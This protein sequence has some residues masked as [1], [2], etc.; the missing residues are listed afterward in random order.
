MRVAV[1]HSF[2]SSTLPSGENQVVQ[3]QVDALRQAGHSVTLVSRHTDMEAQSPQYAV[4]TAVRVAS[5]RGP[6]PTQY[7]ARFRPDV[8]HVHNLFPNIGT[9]WLEKWSGPVVATLHNFRPLC[10]NGLLLRDGQSCTLCPSGARWSSLKYACYR[11]SRPATLPLTLRNRKGPA[12]DR[13][14]RRADVLV[15]LSERSRLTYQEFGLPPAKLALVPNFVSRAHLS[16]RPMPEEVRWIAAGRLTR[17]KGF[18]NLLKMWPNGLPLEIFG[19]GPDLAELQHL[20]GGK[21]IA[22]MGPIDRGE[23]RRRLSEYT[24]LVLPSE[25]RENLP[26][27][28]LESFEAGLPVVARAGSGGADAVEDSGAG[29]VY[30]DAPSLGVALERVRA[31]GDQLRGLTRRAF[32]DTWAADTWLKAMEDQY[33]LAIGRR[34]AVAR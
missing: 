16:H 34:A 27:V 7:I 2:Y 8:V 21:A 24:G 12:H 22:I 31:G 28:V 1:V 18:L 33:R 29:T 20:A 6:D 9:R 30:F 26:S 15:V 11:N 13:L 19:D 5:G 10:A 4:K 14:M 32:E 17:E 25:C 3:D 23:L